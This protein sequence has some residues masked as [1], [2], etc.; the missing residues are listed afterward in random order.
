MILIKCGNVMAI[1]FSVFVCLLPYPLPQ[2]LLRLQLCIYYTFD[3]DPQLTDALVLFFQ[4]HFMCHF[5]SFLLIV[6]KFT[7]LFSYSV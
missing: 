4:S 6:F 5:G 1:I 3:V 7:N 2:Q